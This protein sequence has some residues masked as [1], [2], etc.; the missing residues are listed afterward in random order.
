V[1]FK[2]AKILILTEFRNTKIPFIKDRF[3]FCFARKIGCFIAI[4]NTQK[5]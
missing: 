3:S 2:R 5:S 4:K 1:F